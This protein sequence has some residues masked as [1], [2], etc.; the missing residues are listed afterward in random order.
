[1]KVL[2]QTIPLDFNKMLRL[3]Y[4]IWVDLIKKVKLKKANDDS[5]QFMCMMIMSIAMSLNL[6]LFMAILQAH[7]L[8]N[9][10]YKLHFTF[11]PRSLSN[12]LSFTILFMFPSVAV[13]YLLVFRNNRYKNLLKKFPS[14][15][16]KAFITYFLISMFLPI[17]L[18]WAGIILYKLEMIH[19]AL[20]LT[21]AKGV[22]MNFLN[23]LTTGT[24]GK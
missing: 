11:L 3:Y 15:E 12:I 20:V 1:M 24:K 2:D 6:I 13:N 17:V 9:Y 5:W 8:H 22:L 10:F 4:I 23:E 21:P 18:M 7:I 16:G 14:Y 19:G